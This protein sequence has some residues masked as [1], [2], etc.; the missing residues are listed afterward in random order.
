MPAKSQICPSRTLQ[1]LAELPI[2]GIKKGALSQNC[3]SRSRFFPF[4][5]TAGLLVGPSLDTTSRRGP[6]GIGKPSRVANPHRR[7]LG[8]AADRKKNPKLRSI[9]KFVGRNFQSF[10]R[11]AAPRSCVQ[12]LFLKPGDYSVSIEQF[13]AN[14]ENG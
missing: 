8:P 14:T 13:L 5:H 9:N 6:L 4:S 10:F 2:E 12:E 11:R 7:Q 3:W 1:G